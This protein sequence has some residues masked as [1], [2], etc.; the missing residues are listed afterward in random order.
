MKP[1][2]DLATTRVLVTGGTG[3]LGRAI[4]EKLLARGVEAH[5]LAR[6]DAPELRQLGVQTHRGSVEDPATVRAAVARADIVIHTAAK[7]GVWGDP[8]AFRAINLAGTRNVV[9]ACRQE[10]IRRLVHCSTPS[11]V[12]G[13]EDL[14]GVDESTP[15]PAHFESAYPETKASAERHV[16]AAAGPDLATVSLRPHLIWGPRDPHFVPRIVGRSRAGRLRMVG[17][18]R[19]LVDTIY[20]DNAADAHLLAAERLEP[21]APISGRAYFLSQGE[22]IAVGTMINHL[23]E[24]AGEPPW[25]RSVPAGLA[26]AGGAVLE[27]IYRLL[28]LPGEPLVTRFLARELSRSHWFDIGAARRDL[29][30]AP[31]I[32]TGEGLERLRDWLRENPVP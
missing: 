17:D 14:E 8:A 12:F 15:Y 29:E 4:L 23:L 32:T 5:S 18:G 19:N 2:L 7:A 24:A 31:A 10:G 6:S 28:R 20:I 30:Y 16:L 11:V 27:G 9:E 26:H 25:T 22:P 21:G 13:G 1:V 3:F